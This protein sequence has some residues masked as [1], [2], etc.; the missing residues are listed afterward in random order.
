MRKK[1]AATTTEG[2]SCVGAKVDENFRSLSSFDGLAE[3]RGEV[4]PSS[5]NR[6]NKNEYF[7]PQ[8]RHG[9][10]IVHSTHAPASS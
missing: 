2:F 1:P 8:P 7:I 3:R 6:V 5:R 10:F 4:L 9:L